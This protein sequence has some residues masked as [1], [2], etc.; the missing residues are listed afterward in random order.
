MKNVF[1]FKYMS[2]SYTNSLQSVS[3]VQY[4]QAMEVHYLRLSSYL[5]SSIQTYGHNKPVSYSNWMWFT[6]DVALLWK[7]F[8][9]AKGHPTV[10]CIVSGQMWIRL[11]PTLRIQR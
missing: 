4:L 7:V 6:L 11:S 8:E 10:L 2:V 3:V 9:E 1:L 5:L